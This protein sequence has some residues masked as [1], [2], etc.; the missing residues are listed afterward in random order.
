MRW[1]DPP[2]AAAFTQ[3][4]ELLALLGAVDAAGRVTPHGSAMAELGTHPRLAHMLLRARAAGVGAV[5]TSAVLVAIL[6]ERDLLRGAGGPPPADVQLRLDAVARDMDGVMLAGATVD[7]GLVHR[8]REVAAEW[9]RRLRYPERRRGIPDGATTDAQLRA[10]VVPTSAI[11]RFAR[12]DISV[13]ML[14][15]WAYPDRVAQ[16]RDA[17][18]RFLLRNGRGATLP[19]ADALA[20]AEWI[21]AAQIDDSGRDGRIALAAALD[22]AELLVHAGEQ[23]VAR[24]EIGWND[25]T[26][27][28]QA[29]RRTTL[30]ALV[31]SDS[32]I[33]DA[34]P[35]LIAAALLDGIARAGVGTLPWSDSATSLRQRLRFPASPRLP[36]G[37][38]LMTKR[39]T[40]RSRRGWGRTS[41]ECASSTSCRVLT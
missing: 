3:A 17:P 4:C 5:A 40:R 21:V 29:R 18:G 16:R 26:H 10:T 32:A 6:E 33:P 41:P 28:V 37:L 25:A 34:D 15:A 9:V 31:L 2:P 19:L 36:R 20:Q 30:G 23:V 7:R 1:L 22:P 14:L 13:A 38:T 8:I 11:P 12:D 35:V 27:S 24:D 39:L